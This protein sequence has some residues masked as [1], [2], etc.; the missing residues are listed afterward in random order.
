MSLPRG[1]KHWRFTT[2][3]EKMIKIEEKVVSPSKNLV[4]QMAEVAVPRRSLA[5]ILARIDQLRLVPGTG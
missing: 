3:R 4:F 1:V 5:A 2:L